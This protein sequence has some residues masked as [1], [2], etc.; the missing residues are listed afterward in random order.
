MT[1]RTSQPRFT[2]YHM[3][4]IMVS[5]FGVVIAVN[6]T[7]AWY[8]TSSWSGLVVENTYVA[9][10]QF[11]SRAA[12]M[13]AMAATGIHGEVTLAPQTISYTLKQRDG[14]PAIADTVT[15]HFKRPVGDHQDFQVE[16]VKAGE[17]NFTLAHVVPAGDWI[18]E[19]ISKRNGEIIMHEASRIYMKGQGQ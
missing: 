14:T 10:Q 4:A 11:N 19:V 8:A 13:R 17:G 15:A 9:S 16:L 7:M 3:A 12:A 2:G 6:F 1:T 18:V 5:F